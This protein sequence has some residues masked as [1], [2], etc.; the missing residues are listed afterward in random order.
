VGKLYTSAQ[1]SKIYSNNLCPRIWMSY[2]M[3]LTISVSFYKNVLKDGF[4]RSGVE[5]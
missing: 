1:S 2:G 3:D 5:P 4:E